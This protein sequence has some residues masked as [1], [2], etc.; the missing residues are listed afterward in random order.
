MARLPLFFA[1]LAALAVVAP[2]QI[3][4]HAVLLNPTPSRFDP[5]V[6]VRGDTV[7]ACGLQPDTGGF[8]FVH[9]SRSGDGGRWWPVRELPLAYA[10]GVVDLAVDGEIVVVLVVSYYS[11]L[12]TITSS[13]GG[14]TWALPVRVSTQSSFSETRPAAL[15]LDGSTVNVVWLETRGPGRIWANRS[16]DGGATWQ[17]TDTRLDSGISVQPATN[18]SGLVVFGDGPLVEA[19]W[20]HASANGPVTLLQRSSDGGATWFTQPM[21]AASGGMAC[22]GGDGNL[23]FVSRG[24][25]SPDL[26]STNGGASWQPVAGAG[27]IGWDSVAVAGSDVLVA[28]ELDLTFL[29]QL[30][31]NVSRD[32]GATWLPSPYLIDVPN[33]FDCRAY[34]VGDLFLVHVVFPSNQ[35]PLGAVILSADGGRNWR[36]LTDEAGLGLWPDESGVVVTTRASATSQSTWA[37]VLAGHT[38]R[39]AGTPG[40]GGRVPQ[41]D[42]VG[43]PVL[44]RVFRLAI[45]AARADAP[46]VLFAS[47]QPAVGIGIGLATLYVQAP[48]APT[49]FWTSS[50]GDAEVPVAI[51]ASTAL[52]GLTLISQ[53]F[54]LDAAAGDGFAATRA[55]ESW[56]R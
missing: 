39:G 35:A 14:E 12:F 55:V 28:S 29:Q 7:H 13:D 11:G 2:A 3:P 50:L 43:L 54:V 40:T 31:L 24:S 1:I 19:L 16:L 52:S 17:P 21:V 53:A 33:R 6:V 45:T 48:A 20:V 49:V 25:P 18:S 27:I 5:L 36:L 30:R 37:Y 56:I 38:A 47:F 26:R 44:D 22:G 15:H 32:G 51:P 42:G 4:Q 10:N 46:G 23:M 41:L 9:Y 34:I 8:G